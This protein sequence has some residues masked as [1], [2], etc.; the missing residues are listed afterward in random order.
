MLEMQYEL[1]REGALRSEDPKTRGKLSSWSS[2]RRI[3]SATCQDVMLKAGGACPLV[4]EP[5]RFEREISRARE[6]SNTP[7]INHQLQIEHSASHRTRRLCLGRYGRPIACEDAHTVRP[8][9]IGCRVKNEESRTRSTQSNC[10]NLLV[11][12]AVESIL[13]Y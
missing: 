6:V 8:T 12:I 5:R 9:R 7:T 13:Q 10:E 1:D 3:R 4:A 2:R 11:M